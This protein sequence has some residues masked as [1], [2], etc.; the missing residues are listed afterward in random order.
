M[1]VYVLYGRDTPEQ[2]RVEDLAKRMHDEQLDTELVDADSPRGVQLAENYDVMARPAVILVGP[3]GSPVQ[4]WQGAES[5]PSPGD[6][7]YLA[8]Q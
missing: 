2:R 7:A 8:H 6:V 4:V 1:M 5:L 3:N